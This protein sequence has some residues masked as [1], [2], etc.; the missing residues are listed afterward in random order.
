M[1]NKQEERYSTSFRMGFKS[2]S[3]FKDQTLGI[4]S[5]GKVCKAKCDNLLCA[6]KLMH[7]TLFDPTAQPA[8]PHMGHRLPVRRFEQ[9]CALLST[10]RHPNI[11]QYLGMYQDPDSGVPVLLMELMDISLTHFL[12]S[13]SQPILHHIQVNICHD[14]S[15]ALSYLHSNGIIHRDLS[16]NN[17]LMS[18]NNKAKVTDFGMARLGD[19]NARAS[20][21]NYTMCPGTDVYMP[22]EAVD[23]KPVYTEKIDCFSFGVIIVQILT[24]MFPAPGDR[25]ET[26]EISHPQIRG[27]RVKINIP[28]VDRRQNHIKEI[29]PKN[30]LLLTALDCLKDKDI[31][32]PSAQQLC[33]RIAHLRVEPNYVVSMEANETNEGEQKEIMQIC[34]RIAYQ[35]VESNYGVSTEATE[36]D[37]DRQYEVMQSPVQSGEIA[38]CVSDHNDM[39][40]MVVRDTIKAADGAKQTESAYTTVETVEACE[41]SSTANLGEQVI[42]VGQ[43]VIPSE[44][45]D[46][47]D[48]MSKREIKL[49]LKWKEGEKAP[50][51]MHCDFNAAVNSDTMYIRPGGLKVYAYR[52]S[53]STWSHLPNCP[54][55]ECPSVIVNSLLT[56]IGGTKDDTITNQLFSFIGD[57]RAQ[58]WSEKY[59]PMPTKRWGA[60]AVCT[61]NSTVI[62]AGGEGENEMVLTT[63]EVMNTQT[64]QW[65]TAIDLPQALCYA[66]LVV[67]GDVVYVQGGNGRDQE[68]NQ[69]VYSCPVTCF[70]RSNGTKSLGA[71]LA[72]ALSLP[73][74]RNFQKGRGTSFWVKIADLPVTYSSCVVLQNQLLS[75]GGMDSDDNPTTAIHMYNPVTNSWEVISRIITPRYD[76]FAVVLPGDHLMVVGGRT[77]TGKT[78]LV[79]WATGFCSN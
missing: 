67:C 3:L 21:L 31:E 8:A 55:T 9:E 12:E 77:T 18:G 38:G 28:E 13:A 32:R 66:S 72:N 57:D 19:L 33:E 24:R 75:I 65:S 51:K 5:Y 4:G 10:I 61:V 36:T 41:L 79:E 70:N 6:A 64:H 20:R 58:C 7:E 35:R 44:Q 43:E 16:S 69:S 73:H 53:T 26:I 30:P 1:S 40:Q 27:G 68:P 48:A 54:C 45:I 56:I 42:E 22:P 63:V 60:S 23:D 14:I 17:V 34:E 74:E 37:E 11:V 76:C 25:Y 29:D 62:V 49:C 47:A 15:L 46:G 2:V 78:N 52:M 71:R 59:P 50:C 39:Q